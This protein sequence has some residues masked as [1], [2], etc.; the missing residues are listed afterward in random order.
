[1]GSSKAYRLQRNKWV[2]VKN[3]QLCKGTLLYGECVRENI[4]PKPTKSEATNQ[5]SYYKYTLQVID[6][7]RLGDQS[8]SNMRFE[9]R[10][11]LNKQHC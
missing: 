5:E 10:Y 8:L 7:L 6:A 1:M 2:K 4:E 3:L 11:K 9:E